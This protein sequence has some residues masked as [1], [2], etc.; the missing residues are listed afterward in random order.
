MEETKTIS[1]KPRDEQSTIELWQNFGWNLMSSQEINNTDSHLERHGDTIYNV[2]S[3]ENYVKITFK[4]NKNIPNYD[5]LVSLENQ[6]ASN[7]V[8]KSKSI[9][10]SVILTGLG[11]LS[12]PSFAEG[13]YFGLIAVLLLAGGLTWLVVTIL[14]NKKISIENSVRYKKRAEIIAEANG[15]LV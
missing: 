15:L 9:K 13:W 12:L 11:A 3:K 6:Y 4:R 2:T 1:V 8:L 10:G 7:P 5:K 14:K